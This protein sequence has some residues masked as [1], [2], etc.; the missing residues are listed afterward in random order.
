MLLEVWAQSR[1]CHSCGWLQY[2]IGLIV[3]ATVACS[4]G[5][6]IQ[7]FLPKEKATSGSGWSGW[8]SSNV[9]ASL[10][11][12]W[13]SSFKWLWSRAVLL[14]ERAWWWCEAVAAVLCGPIS[15]GVHSP[16]T[17]AW[18]FVMFGRACGE[19]RDRK[20]RLSMA[21]SVWSFKGIL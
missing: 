5:R 6:C 1:R 15:S 14:G 9:G 8:S 17:A 2:L 13:K 3:C 18:F 20:M 21:C 12:W 16:G 7:P 10:C 19:A 4:N 11:L